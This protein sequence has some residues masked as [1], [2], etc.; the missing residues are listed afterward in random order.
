M[1]NLLC[2]VAIIGA[3]T[4]GLAAERSARR[5]GARTLLIDDRF[6]GTTCAAVG[7]MPS[8]LLIAAAHAAHTVRQ[9]AIFGINA[10]EPRIDGAAV[11]R[12]IRQER[13]RFV[14][15]TQE[16]IAKIPDGIRIEARAHFIDRNTLA[17]DDG[18]R[19]SAKT[20]VVATGSRPRIP[21][22]FEVLGDRILTNE[23]VFELPDLPRSVAVVGAGPLGLELAQ[24]FVR[25]GVDTEV[26]DEGNR[27]AGLH[28]DEVA[29]E[30][31]SILTK[32]LPI[33]LKVS[34]SVEREGD[35]AKV[36]WSGPSSG[37]KRFE[38]VLVATGRPPDIHGLVLNATGLAMDE[39]ETPLCDPETLQCGDAP[40]FLAGDAD[41]RRPVLH[42]ASSE[43]AIAGRN[44]ASFP[45]VHRAR[46]SVAFSIMFTD[47]PLAMLGGPAADDAV[48]GRA[49][50]ADQG[51]AKI[52]ARNA[53]LIRLYAERPDGRLVGAAMVG[54]GAD[55]IAHLL[56]WAIERGESATMLLDLPY[57]HPTFEEGLKPALREICEAVNAPMVPDRDEGTPPG[58]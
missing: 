17:L 38:R 40:F 39:K 44:A 10:P 27:L 35:A 34:L 49:S 16:S 30:L 25:L 31:K 23:T 19:V 48:I 58:A 21:P 57:Y 51:R 41:A 7:C 37:K 43:G 36:S 24:A 47:P 26:F 5:A 29:A 20:V 28:D 46:R 56:A 4:A 13:D 22:M 2:D 15:A 8:K 53:G 45:I 18:R 3:G 42:E 33:H 32:E 9:A 11:M 50:Y 52:E 54:P 1:T 14:R 6:A 55:H 12:R